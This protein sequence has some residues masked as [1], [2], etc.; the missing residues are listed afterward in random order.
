M[1]HWAFSPALLV[2]LNFLLGSVEVNY[3]PFQWFYRLQN[4]RGR[5]WRWYLKK[6]VLI[7]F[8]YLNM[9]D[10]FFISGCFLWETWTFMVKNSVQV[11]LQLDRSTYFWNALKLQWQGRPINYEFILHTYGSIIHH[12]NI[13]LCSPTNKQTCRPIGGQ[14]SRPF[15]NKRNG[16]CDSVMI[17][18]EFWPPS[19]NFNVCFD[20]FY[21]RSLPTV[22]KLVA[23]KYFC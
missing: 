5:F 2:S 9:D 18:Y 11:L 17:K 21:D 12:H 15:H 13:Y 4:F 8:I 22:S 3:F 14:W 20:N 23:K 16:Q 7:N 19:S 1:H 10:N 6:K